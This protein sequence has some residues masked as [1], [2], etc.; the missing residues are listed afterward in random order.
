MDYH[1]I[2]RTRSFFSSYKIELLFCFLFLV[3]FTNKFIIL[4]ILSLFVLVIYFM[5]SLYKKTLLI[6]ELKKILILIVIFCIYCFLSFL[7]PFNLSKILNNDLISFLFSFF[8]TDGSIFV[9]FVPLLALSMLKLSKEKFIRLF[10]LNFYLIG[11][12]TLLLVLLPTSYNEYGEFTGLYDAHN[13]IGSVLGMYFVI[14]VVM[15]FL[16]PKNNILIISTIFSG[17]GLVVSQSRGSFLAAILTLAIL[18]FM[19][20]RK[21]KKHFSPKK[22][23][24][25]LSSIATSIILL[26]L[27][28]VKF[29]NLGE[30]LF[31]LTNFKTG[32]AGI[33]LELYER[34]L[35]YFLWSPLFGIGFGSFNDHIQSWLGI[36]GI[37]YIPHQYDIITTEQGVGNHAH[38]SYLQFLSEIGLFGFLLIM[39]VWVLISRLLYN[40]VK[41]EYDLTIRAIYSSSIFAIYYLLIVSMTEHYM[42]SGAITLNMN[43]LIGLTLAYIN[44]HKILSKK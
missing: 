22:F 18:L 8:R 28:I 39:F 17:I 44:T 24:I 16:G 40:N 23:K 32:T 10:L 26:G 4:N 34:A 14:G 43:V 3:N 30:R 20:L 6:S 19:F 25:L 29:T 11:F 15:I 41:S 33:R 37:F 2:E 5:Y 27:G 21:K 1:F 31:L 7:F 12:I 13:A 9:G 35:S 42:G 36:K 38:N